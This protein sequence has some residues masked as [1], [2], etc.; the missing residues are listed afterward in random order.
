VRVTYDVCTLVFSNDTLE[1]LLSSFCVLFSPGVW[2]E[3]SM[4]C[5]V[6]GK[7]GLL[8][9]SFLDRPRLRLHLSAVDEAPTTADCL[10]FQIAGNNDVPQQ[11]C[12][13]GGKADLPDSCSCMDNKIM[14]NK[15]LE[16]FLA[17]PTVHAWN[18]KI[19][20]FCQPYGQ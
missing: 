3:L 16:L 10:R 15:T 19:D 4:L 9:A 1:Q 18:A 5:Q 12:V 11:S 8:Q 2:G 13:R 14:H 6:R 7:Q 20:S 17:E